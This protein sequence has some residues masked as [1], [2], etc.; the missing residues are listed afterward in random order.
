MGD[1]TD[2]VI[3]CGEID[4]GRLEEESEKSIINQKQKKM[5][6]VKS[7]ITH[8]TGSGSF[9]NDYGALQENGKKLLFVHE[10]TFEDG[11]VMQANHKTIAS[12]FAIG[13]EA[14]YEIT[15]DNAHGKSGKVRKPDDGSYGGGSGGGRNN[16]GYLKGI[17]VGHAVNNAVNLICAG[18]ELDTVG[19]KDC[20]TTEEKIYETAKVIIAISARLKSE[21]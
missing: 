20:K 6:K 5:T 8:I 7:K 2:H 3:R 12:P 17:E 18:M 14:E 13:Q 15:R 10:Y 1:M 9:E 11:T 21:Q 16:D 4:Q 19:E